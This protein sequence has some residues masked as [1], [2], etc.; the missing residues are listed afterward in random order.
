M[1]TR[2]TRETCSYQ[3]ATTTLRT[4]RPLKI[5][6]LL[7]AQLRAG[8]GLMGADQFW[9]PTEGHVRQDS[10]YLHATADKFVG[11][12]LAQYLQAVGT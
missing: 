1:A 3:Q 7:L 12:S 2:T 8:I 6:S 5:Q 4:A 10:Y 11:V 9:T